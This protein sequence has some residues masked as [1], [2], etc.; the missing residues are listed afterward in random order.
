MKYAI[1]FHNTSETTPDIDEVKSTG[2]YKPTGHQL[3]Y[4]EDFEWL[5]N[6]KLTVR[7]LEDYKYEIRNDLLEMHFE[8]WLE[9]EAKTDKEAINKAQKVLNKNGF[10]WVS[11]F[12]LLEMPYER[13]IAHRGIDV[14]GAEGLIEI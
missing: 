4:L 6:K 3:W 1:Y 9:F 10:D 8:C 13:K 11:I 5:L 2:E 12:Y 14:E 7:F